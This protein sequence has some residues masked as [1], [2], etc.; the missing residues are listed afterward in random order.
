[1]VTCG[2]GVGRN[3]SNNEGRYEGWR[4]RG[5]ENEARRR[6]GGQAGRQV[7]IFLKLLYK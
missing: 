4:G 1:M 3:G 7:D 2:G 5:R 6:A